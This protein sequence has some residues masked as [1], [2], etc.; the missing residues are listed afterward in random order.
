MRK[1]CFSIPTMGAAFSTYMADTLSP[2]T[3]IA[4][5]SKR[6]A[7]SVVAYAWTPLPLNVTCANGI[8]WFVA[9]H[10]IGDVTEGLELGLVHFVLFRWLAYDSR[11][12][13][14]TEGVKYL[15]RLY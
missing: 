13:Q 1:A 12:G 10:C 2:P 5:T 11:I 9:A 14:S 15:E 4:V 7:A 3:G 8:G 6:P